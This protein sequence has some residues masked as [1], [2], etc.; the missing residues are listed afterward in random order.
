ML[1]R[2]SWPADSRRIVYALAGKTAATLW[3]VAAD[4]GTPTQI[5]R[6]SGR[7]PTW[8]PGGDAIAVVRSD[9]DH[10]TV[11]FITAAG[12]QG[13]SAAGD[14]SHRATSGGRVVA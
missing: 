7:V 13:A 11:H 2:A 3:T 8:S 14:R 4:G 9:N 5:E 6:A 10:P 1:D 12:A